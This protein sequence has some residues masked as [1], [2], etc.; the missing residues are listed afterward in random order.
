V[1][2]MIDSNDLK[3]HMEPRVIQVHGNPKIV[4]LVDI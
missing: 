1:E 2:E 3:W 4:D